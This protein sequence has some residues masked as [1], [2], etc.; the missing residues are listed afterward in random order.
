M[1][2]PKKPLV[3]RILR[4]LWISIK[5]LFITYAV[6]FSLT[7]TALFIIGYIYVMNP[8][9]EVKRLKAENPQE[10]A[11][12]VQH[13]KKLSERE[14]ND[15]L[16]HEFIPL[17][18][19][20]K[21]LVEAVIA[22]EDDGFYNHP[23]FSLVAIA[24]AIEHN[25]SSGSRKRGASTITQQLAKNLFL[26]PERSFERKAKELGYTLLMERILEKDRILELYLNYAQWG[27]NV[28]GCEAASKTYF[29]KRSSELTRSQA[30]RMAA[31]LAMPSKLTP[32]HTK[33]I[34]MGKRLLVIANNLYLKGVID[35]SGYYSI[36]GRYPPDYSPPEAD[37]AQSADSSGSSD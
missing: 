9:N 3:L 35:V 20:S 4:I 5:T 29:R 18:S 13:R 27:K 7:M 16:V 14:E 2:E 31:V 34:F 30:V 33:S 24:D 26:S 23:G 25:R 8:I 11:F 36:T 21:I 19:I 6:A 28:F 22:A 32:H 15:S 10:T 1:T 37:T 12:M 17:N